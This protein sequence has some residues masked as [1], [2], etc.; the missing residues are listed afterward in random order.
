MPS[1][2]ARGGAVAVPPPSTASAIRFAPGVIP[3]PGP[4]KPFTGFRSPDNRAA[5]VQQAAD[6]ST[7]SFNCIP[8]SE[9]RVVTYDYVGGEVIEEVLVAKGGIFPEQV[10]LLDSHNRSSMQQQLGAARE[11]RLDGQRWICRAY[12]TPDVAAAEEAFKKVKAGH[13]T[14][15]SV[16][17]FVRRAVRIRPGEKETIDGRVWAVD[18]LPLRVCLTWEVIELSMTPIGADADA[19][20]LH[21]Q[22]I[23]DSSPKVHGFR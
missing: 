8:T 11:F 19:K 3:A 6:P 15:V 12:L 20:I 18:K 13:A 7:L 16:G 10:P 1:Y 5:G 14:D 21:E 17:Y 4:P 9:T 2:F 23:R 22:A